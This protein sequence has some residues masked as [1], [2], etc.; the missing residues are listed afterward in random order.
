[1]FELRLTVTTCKKS[2]ENS[3]HA[4]ILGTGQRK[5]SVKDKTNV[6]AELKININLDEGFIF[7]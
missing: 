5:V 7:L 1:M 2:E 6:F 4:Q 3:K